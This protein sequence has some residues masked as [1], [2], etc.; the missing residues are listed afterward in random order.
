MKDLDA[1]DRVAKD[2]ALRRVLDAADAMARELRRREL[3]GDAGA[4]DLCEEFERAR[5]SFYAHAPPRVRGDLRHVAE[6][7]ERGW[8]RDS[9]LQRDLRTP[10]AGGSLVQRILGRIGAVLAASRGRS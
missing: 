5:D 6:A 9:G 7:L 10:V 8:E 3:A 4:G 2:R 1:M